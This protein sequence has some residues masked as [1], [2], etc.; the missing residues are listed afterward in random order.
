MYSL[1][2]LLLVAFLGILGMELSFFMA[3]SI[4]QR[5][6]HAKYMKVVRETM[7]LV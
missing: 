2:Q 5:T 7:K 6:L 4:S 1:E 3:I